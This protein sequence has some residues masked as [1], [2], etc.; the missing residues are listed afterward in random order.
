[1][2]VFVLL[3]VGNP[4]KIAAKAALRY[5]GQHEAPSRSLD[6]LNPSRN[7][8][9]TQVKKGPQLME[10]SGDLFGSRPAIGTKSLQTLGFLTVALREFP[11]GASQKTQ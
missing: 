7:P 1:M 11:A 6:V 2:V 8:S 5:R 4:F 3:G 10:P 9:E